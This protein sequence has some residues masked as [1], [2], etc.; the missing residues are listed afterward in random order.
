[1]NRTTYV[2]D[3]AERMIDA[4]TKDELQSIRSE[5]AEDIVNDA[6]DLLGNRVKANIHKIMQGDKHQ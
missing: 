3:A 1:M 6:Y 2:L 4:Q 5:F